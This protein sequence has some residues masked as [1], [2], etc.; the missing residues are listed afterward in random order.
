MHTGPRVTWEQS[1]SS[2]QETNT[3]EYARAATAYIAWPLALYE[4]V[5]RAP[6][7][8]WYRT[9]M[10]QATVLGAIVWAVLLVVFALPLLL[11]VA[12]GGPPETQTIEMYAVAMILDVIVFTAAGFIVISS[13]I[14]A[15]HGELFTLPVITALSERLFQRRRG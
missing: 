3:D 1:G 7:S 4:L 13:A 15:S 8:L 12:L 5:R 10:R 2:S 9:H 14:R 6:G 11:F